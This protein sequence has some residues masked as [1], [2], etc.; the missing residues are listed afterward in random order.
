MNASGTPTSSPTRGRVSLPPALRMRVQAADGG[1]QT[2]EI[3]AG[4]APAVVASNFARTYSLDAAKSLKL[5]QLIA[6]HMAKNDIPMT[7]A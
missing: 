3:Y 6:A 5:Q 1:S 7:D 2:I 4:D